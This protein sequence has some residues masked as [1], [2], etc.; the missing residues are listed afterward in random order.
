MV[1]YRRGDHHFAQKSE[2]RIPGHILLEVVLGLVHYLYYSDKLDQTAG[3]KKQP[4][5]A[6]SCIEINL[7]ELNNTI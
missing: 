1:Q 6:L 3:H 2:K 5:V 4:K 7:L